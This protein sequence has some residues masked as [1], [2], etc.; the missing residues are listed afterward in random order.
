MLVDGDTWASV[1]DEAMS[2]RTYND[3]SL[4]KNV[5]FWGLFQIAVVGL[6]LLQLQ[7]SLKW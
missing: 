3:P 4:H 5:V 2:V 1:A 6:V 7:K